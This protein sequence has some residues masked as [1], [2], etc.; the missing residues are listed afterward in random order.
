MGVS[1]KIWLGMEAETRPETPYTD[2]YI[3]Y[4]A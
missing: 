2:I 4:I 1:A 3:V